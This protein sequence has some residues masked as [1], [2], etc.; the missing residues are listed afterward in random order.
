MPATSPKLPPD[1]HAIVQDAE[2]RNSTL[3]LH[4]AGEE[5]ER[6][7]PTRA[8]LLHVEPDGRWLV[9]K[10]Y[11]VNGPSLHTGMDLI[12]VVGSGARRLGFHTRVEGTELHQL[13]ERNRVPVLRL[14][15][16]HNIHSAQRRAYFR[17]S[18][19]GTDS[20][21]VALHGIEDVRS[22]VAAERANKALHS[23]AEPGRVTEPPAL[24]Q[25]IT[26]TVFDLSGN[27]LS[28]LVPA[29]HLAAL[30]AHDRFWTELLLPDQAHPLCFVVRRIRYR[31]D[32]PGPV[33]AAF[34]FD[35]RH[36]RAHEEFITEA[37]CRY[38][39][40]L[41]RLQLQRAR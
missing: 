10:P 17:I 23:G 20:P 11:S 37:V 18:A 26:G 9:E 1:W 16:P 12:G 32:D 5:G 33:H 28:M 13:N 21:T 29:A 39:T 19:M 14:A 27:G 24:G 31:R 6:H 34:T 40:R 3:E 41:Q 15:E 7:G 38:T 35:F 2:R 8:R 22:A 30:N 4:L 36:N 25:P